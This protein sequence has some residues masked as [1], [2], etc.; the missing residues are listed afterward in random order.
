MEMCPQFDLANFDY[1][2]GDQPWVPSL[3][4]VCYVFGDFSLIQGSPFSIHCNFY[5]RSHFNSVYVTGTL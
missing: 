3:L 4:L 2:P 5:S 1:L